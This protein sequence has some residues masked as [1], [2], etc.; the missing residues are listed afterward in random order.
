M[1]NYTRAEMKAAAKDRLDG[2]WGKAI[3]AMLLASLV[4]GAIIVIVY[5]ILCLLGVLCFS[6]NAVA[7]GSII[8]VVAYLLMA[9][10]IIFV[11]GPIT[12][13]YDFFSLGLA[14]GMDV[15][16]TTPYEC[17]ASGQYGRLTL[18]FFMQNL[19]IFLWSLLFMIP[20]IIK[21]LSYAMMPFILMD[22]PEMGWQEA[23]NESKQMMNGHKG[24][25]FVLYLSFILW[26]LLVEVTWGIASLYVAPY[27]QQT[28][29][30]FYRSLKEESI[31]VPQPVPTEFS[32]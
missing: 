26:L 20:G 17:F 5:Y 16:A 19:F 28:L 18:A 9:G 29:A 10:S 27:M 24:D 21:S 14:R 1:L 3:G 25:L 15:K 31:A 23:L 8:M 7:A 11:L 32:A 30:N 6:A 12:I 2:K 13:G 4:P 22:H